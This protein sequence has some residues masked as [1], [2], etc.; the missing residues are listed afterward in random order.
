MDWSFQVIDI[1]PCSPMVL[2]AVLRLNVLL[3]A[4]ELLGEDYACW[5]LFVGL[6]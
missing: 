1:G 2:R 4:K 3:D 5:R 6:A